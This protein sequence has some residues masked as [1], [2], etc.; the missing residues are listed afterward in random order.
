MNITKRIKGLSLKVGPLGENDRLLTLLS[1]QEGISRLAVPGARKPRSSLS[2]ATPL[3]LLDVEIIQTRGLHKVRHVNVI[4]SYNCV[5]RKLETLAGAQSIAELSLLLVA[6][7]DPIEGM[8]N[9]VIF[10]LNRLEKLSQDSQINN[11]WILASITQSFLHL[12]ALGGYGLPVQLCC[13]SGRPLIPPLGD[14]DW[15]C[16]F[17]PQDGFAI[18]SH[19]SAVIE[20]NPSE[21]ALIQKLLQADL[22]LKKNGELLGPTNVWIKLF[23]L[24]EYW[25]TNNLHKK[26]C[27]LE[28]FRESIKI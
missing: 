16:S 21:L 1:N 28:M 12:L 25:T 13:L 4:K 17:N 2:S 23:S 5:S 20:L 22:P 7:N 27:S 9:T 26:I 11:T 6:G 24:V 10:H 18:G 8:L 3:N 19:P 15:R 14:W